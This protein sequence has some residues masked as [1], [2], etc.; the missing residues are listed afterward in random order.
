MAQNPEATNWLDTQ[1]SALP[2]DFAQGQRTQHF[3]IHHSLYLFLCVP[4]TR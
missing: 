2:F 3:A 1:H 4:Q